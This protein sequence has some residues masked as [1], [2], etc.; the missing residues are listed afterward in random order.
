MK[1]LAISGSLRA[2]STNTFLLK[3]ALKLAPANVETVLF[4][5]L[6]DLPHFNPD[7]DTEAPPEVVVKF[8]A[9][10]K[11]S[12]ALLVCSPEYIHG[13]PGS[14]KNA[15]D[16]IASSGELDGMPVGIINASPSMDG[17]S[18]AQESLREIL[19]V[20][21]QN[22]VE[23]AVLKVPAVRT[24]MDAHGEITDASLTESLKSTI[25][26]LILAIKQ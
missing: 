15:F 26:A 19:K 13:V 25:S 1:I 23:G 10:L 4:E 7:L 6:A 2:K 24:R 21:S 3:Q 16:W 12:N 18:F 9:L 22:I 20:L 11:S 5:G 17:A 8:R 14:L